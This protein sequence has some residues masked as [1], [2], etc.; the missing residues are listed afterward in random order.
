MKKFASTFSLLNLIAM[1]RLL[2]FFLLLFSL[3]NSNAQSFKLG[4]KGGSNISGLSGLSFKDGYNF[5]Y[6]VGAFSE[7]MFSEKFGF[8][9]ELLLSEINVRP[10]AQFSS[11]YSQALSNITQI[12][13]QYI[14]V[15]VLLNYK[16]A[17]ILSVQVG[18]QFGILRDQTVSITTNAGNAFKRGDLSMLA[19]FQLNLPIGRIYGRYMVGLSNINDI[20][21]RDKWTNTGLQL[22]IGF[23]L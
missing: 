20:D 22:G 13:L 21:N 15:P 3:S 8:Q 6:H 12:K 23:G 9:P 1:K 17:K 16:P 14:T 19:G 5:G 7:I 10:G 4:I 18:P 2:F 11:L